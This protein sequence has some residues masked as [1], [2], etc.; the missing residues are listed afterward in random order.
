MSERKSRPDH[1]GYEW[2]VDLLWERRRRRRE[3][4]TEIDRIK[5]SRS[6]NPTSDRPADPERTGGVTHADRA[7]D[8]RLR[9]QLIEMGLVKRGDDDD[10]Q[11]A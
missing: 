5:M 6:I 2:R 8:A 11:A 3:Q 7:T 1:Y 9:R 10:P 4:P